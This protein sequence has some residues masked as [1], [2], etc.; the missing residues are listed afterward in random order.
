MEISPEL[1]SYI[2]SALQKG[3]TPDRLKG[4]L[5]STGWPEAEVDAALAQIL[6]QAAPTPGGAG[7]VASPLQTAE[8]GVAKA[9]MQFV[10]ARGRSAKILAVIF[11]VLLAFAAISAGAYFFWF[12][13]L[14]EVVINRMFTKLQSVNSGRLEQTVKSSGKI[15]AD[16]FS[17]ALEMDGAYDIADIANPKIA[18]K[19]GFSYTYTPSG[20]SQISE[21][22]IA[23]SQ[24]P[25]SSSVRGEARFL[26][27]TIYASLSQ[28]PELPMVNT[29]SLVDLWVKIPLSE[30]AGA[31]VDQLQ[32]ED[33]KKDAIL[34]VAAAHPPLSV[35]KERPTED[36]K[37]RSCRR[38]DI[39]L[40]KANL[41]FIFKES[42]KLSAGT[43][44]TTEEQEKAIDG[45]IDELM[46]YVDKI[47]ID[48]FSLW[49]GKKDDLPCRLSLKTTYKDS[50]SANK[51][52]AVTFELDS[53]LSDLNAP[54]AVEAPANTLTAEQY[55]QKA[56][57]ESAARIRPTA[58]DSER[59]NH[60]QL[61]KEVL[62]A[63]KL[64][65]KKFP[66]TGGRDDISALEKPFAT[67]EGGAITVPR[68][69][70][71]GTYHYWS[72]NGSTA[73]IA[74]D[75]E[76]ADMFAK[77]KKMN[78]GNSNGATGCGVNGRICVL[79]K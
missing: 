16:S 70:A 35:F 30:Y 11:F 42:A 21:I 64:T 68:D 13:N 58:E 18:Q 34:A 52:S 7:A 43:T 37:G 76:D 47:A 23:A 28:I 67:F 24:L 9:D 65:A 10:P 69:P 33:E 79:L 48:E 36:I 71:G 72:I 6:N 45:S 5:V 15:D 59:I 60:L 41:R 17:L 22:G 27:K 1:I 20:G 74:V 40:N 2:Q 4:I 49:I 8:L 78:T 77:Y 66:A 14:P 61:L 54:V 63:S 26:N 62:E 38:F 56:Y 50:V 3:L 39:A 32:K 31:E 29:S 46:K 57:S 44:S 75:L 19:L 51:D 12:R 53:V 55:Y 73:T 25:R